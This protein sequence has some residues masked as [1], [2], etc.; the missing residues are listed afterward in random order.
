MKESLTVITPVY[1]GQEYL[2]ETVASIFTN[3]GESFELDYIIIN[4]GSTD[5]TME[6]SEK[7]VKTYNFRILNQKNMG[8]SYSVNRG[9]LAA[10]YENIIVVNADDIILPSAYFLKAADILKYNQNIVATYCNWKIIDE[11]GVFKEDVF[12]ENFDKV[13]F[14]SHFKCYP[15]PGTI[16]RKTPALLIGG[17]AIKYRFV[18]DYD[19]WLKLSDFGDFCFVGEFGAAWRSHGKSTSNAQRNL[20]MAQER[21]DVIKEYVSGRNLPIKFKRLALSSAYYSAALLSAFSRKIPGRKFIIKSLL[22]RLKGNQ[23]RKKI[24]IL[25]C[26]LHPLS[27]YLLNFLIRKKFGLFLLEKVMN[28]QVYRFTSK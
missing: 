15:G 11:R 25:Y 21:I 2:E 12:L 23:I 6:L 27:Y 8:E 16:F 20:Q 22:F 17:R 3:L 19:F 28:K 9:L 14:I 13:K 10:R 26:L 7:L 1:N 24:V 18:G 4:D 5:K